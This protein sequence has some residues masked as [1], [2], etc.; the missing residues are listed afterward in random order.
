MPEKVSINQPKIS[1]HFSKFQPENQG[2]GWD[3]LWK[4]KTTPWDRGHYNPALEDTLLQRGGFLGSAL[5]DDASGEESQRRKKA[6]VPGCGR[7]YDVTLLAAFGYD[8]YGLEYSST[9][10]E[11]CREEAAGVEDKIT[12]RDQKV[13][14]GKVTFVQGD[15][16][17][18]GWLEEIGV[19]EGRFDL[20]YDY[21]FFCALNPVLR[22]KWALRMSQLLAPSPHGNLICLEFPTEK[23]PVNQGPPFASPPAAYMEHL[24]HPGEDIPYNENGHIKR[25][26]LREVSPNGLERV[27]HWQ[28]QRT[29]DVGK[30][31]DGRVQDWVAIWR[32]R[33]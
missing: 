29:H 30:D 4:K 18:N 27:A 14:R 9:A 24:S 5:R 10:V 3:E 33:N 17:K 19:E 22:P 15:F 20:I 12:A 21:T 25:D 26:P 13:G 1:E 6:L 2:D 8:A 16:F 31:E 23:D 28:P 32:R 11:I 7:G